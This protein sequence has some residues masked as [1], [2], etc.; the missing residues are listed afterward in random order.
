MLKVLAALGRNFAV[1]AGAHAFARLANLLV[2]ALVGRWLGAEA[3]GSYAIASSIGLCFLLFA[4]SG[5]APRLVREGAARPGEADREY[6][7]SLGAKAVLLPLLALGIV[8]VYVRPFASA[9]PTLCALFAFSGSL[10]SISA[11]NNS[12]CRARGRFD[13][14][15]LTISIQTLAF[16]SMAIAALYAGYPM[17]AIGWAAIASTAM[18]VAV[19]TACARRFVRPSVS[20]HH[21]A[22]TLRS[23]V[24][25]AT[26]AAAIALTQ[27]DVVILALVATPVDVGRYAAVSRLM[28]G[29]VYFV[30][31]AAD[32]AIPSATLRFVSGDRARFWHTSASLVRLVLAAAVPAGVLLA[33]SARFLI[34]LVYGPAFEPAYGL[35]Q[36]GGFYLALKLCTVP[37]H[38]VLT[39]TGRQAARARSVGCT[40]VVSALTILSL[41]VRHGA[42]GAVI[43]LACG[44]LAGLLVASLA[45]RELREPASQPS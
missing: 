34:Q 11:L 10:E 8:A 27:L 29:G 28:R 19:S 24:P 39:V 36:L 26:I 21:V 32:V 33:V 3:L 9:D 41:G 2:F 44:E 31:L 13:L 35:L 40:L 42:A 22:R 37:F 25:Y 1:I 16:V 5:L 18:E 43:G 45:M 6:A 38:T 14:E 7:E 17:T 12:V 15:A 4:D 20:L 23:A 30:I